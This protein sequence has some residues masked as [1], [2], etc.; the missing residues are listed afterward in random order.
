MPPPF[1]IHSVAD[2]TDVL[3]PQMDMPPMTVWGAAIA[4][5]CLALVGLVMGLKQ[6]PAGQAGCPS[7]L[8]I[9][10]KSAA[11][12]R[13]RP[14]QSG[15]PRTVVFNGPQVTAPVAEAPKPK[16]AGA[17][18]VIVAGDP[19]PSAADDEAPPPAAPPQAAPASPSAQPQSPTS[20]NPPDPM[21][22]YY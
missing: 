17:A 22:N 14:S 9:R 11:H 19:E 13:R 12:R 8:V 21:K 10:R 3:M 20:G 6:T 7:V 1:S 18:A 16:P 5:A 2:D 4:I 15:G